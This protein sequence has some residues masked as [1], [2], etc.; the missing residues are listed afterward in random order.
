MAYS[1]LRT[2]VAWEFDAVGRPIAM[3]DGVGVT[4]WTYDTTGQV[5]SETNPAGA[6]ISHAY[7]KAG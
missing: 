4:G 5:L 3:T 2:T 6:T 7:N 1:S